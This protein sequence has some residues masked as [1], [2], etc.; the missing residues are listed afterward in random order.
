MTIRSRP[1]E[2][3]RG[4]IDIKPEHTRRA[5]LE[6]VSKTVLPRNMSISPQA[7][8]ATLEAMRGS[9]LIKNHPQ[10][11]VQACVDLRFL[12]PPQH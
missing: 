1:R 10:S 3:V 6:F 11:E 8:A 9:G 12:D 7:F 5:C 4:E 2:F